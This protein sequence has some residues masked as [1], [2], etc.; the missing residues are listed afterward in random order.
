[1]LSRHQ[2]TLL[3]Q[4]IVPRSAGSVLRHSAGKMMVNTWC[5]NVI[6]ADRQNVYYLASR[7]AAVLFVSG[8]GCYQSSN[9]QTVR[10]LLRHVVIFRYVA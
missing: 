5:N 10:P 8:F 7:M 4:V 3:G 2:I 1:M 6:N 9:A